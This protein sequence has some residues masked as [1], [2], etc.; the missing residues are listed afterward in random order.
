MDYATPNPNALRDEEET[1]TPTVPASKAT[2]LRQAAAEKARVAAQGVQ[3]KA[4]QLKNAASEKAQQFKSYAGDK[5]VALKEEASQKAHEV[6]LAAAD[7]Y[8]QG[9]AKA[10]D[11]H[12]SSEEYVRQ[13]PTKCVLG[14]FGVGLLIGLLARRR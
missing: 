14:A 12:A 5:A 11:V 9:K 4:T 10:K 1:T 6:K 3:N 13:H 2:E 8:E 7:K